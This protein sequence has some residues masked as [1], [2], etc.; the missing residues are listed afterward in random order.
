MTNLGDEHSGSKTVS[1]PDCSFRAAP[2]SS[3]EESTNKTPVAVAM[4]IL[5]RKPRLRRPAYKTVDAQL[6]FAKCSIAC[7]HA[8]QAPVTYSHDAFSVQQLCCAE[9]AYLRRARSD[10]PT[11]AELC[12]HHSSS[13]TKRGPKNATGAPA[14]KA[15]GLLGSEQEDCIGYAA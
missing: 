1:P 15:T 4:L 8:E 6:R 7:Q 10:C 14:A 2:V 9:L 11:S 3:N 5:T 13:S 12:S